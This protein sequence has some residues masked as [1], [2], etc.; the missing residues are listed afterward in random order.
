[1]EK[2]APSEVDRL[3]RE[4]ASTDAEI[5]DVVYELYRITNEE[6]IMVGGAP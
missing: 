6:Q 4:I 5:D 3:E 2:L 1:V